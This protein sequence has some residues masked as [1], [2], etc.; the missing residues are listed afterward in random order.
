MQAFKEPPSAAEKKK[1]V[2][3]LKTPLPEDIDTELFS[4]DAFLRSLGRMSLSSSR[5]AFSPRL[6]SHVQPPD[7]EAHG[8]L[9]TLHSHLNH[10]CAPNLSVRHFD[11]RTALA[12]IT[13]V[14][15]RPIAVGEE[16]LITYVNP[17]LPLKARRWELSAWGFGVCWCRRCKEEDA[18]Q[19]D[20][21][22]AGANGLGAASDPDLER[23]LKAGLGV[24]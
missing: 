10:S 22:G 14:A 6:A 9:Y 17:E 19:K 15:K 3:L 23:E 12:R 8:G 13:L 7:L 18:A 11:K 20:E 2:R 4:Y 16:L 21:P 5:H 1:L 24:M